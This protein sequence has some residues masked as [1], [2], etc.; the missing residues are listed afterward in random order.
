MPKQAE[1]A[2]VNREAVYTPNKNE[3]LTV[4]GEKGRQ[5]TL[6]AFKLTQPGLWVPGTGKYD[7][8]LNGTILGADFNDALDDRIARQKQSI[9]IML[10]HL[11]A[12]CPRLLGTGDCPHIGKEENPK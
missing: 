10:D 9:D 2:R 3:I 7:I 5:T 1:D 8:Q 6:W 4:R 12:H 11:K